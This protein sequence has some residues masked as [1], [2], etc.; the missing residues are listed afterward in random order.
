MREF[1]LLHLLPGSFDDPICFS[2][3]HEP[4]LDITAVPRKPQKVVTKEHRKNL[5]PHWDVF[6]TL[7]GRF[8]Y[9]YTN[10]ND[11]SEIASWNHPIPD[12]YDVSEKPDAFDVTIPNSIPM[13]EALSYTWVL[14]ENPETVYVTGCSH[15]GRKTMQVTQNLF[16]ALRHLQ[17]TNV[18][19]TLWVDA[20]CINQRNMSKRSD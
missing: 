17:Y 1:R 2:V 16:D 3:T 12:A 7:E 10:P 14:L 18:M 15:D 5:P 20:I 13:Y 9:E 8:I 19:R 4:F 11:G 6:V